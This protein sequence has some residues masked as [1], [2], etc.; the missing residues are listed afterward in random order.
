MLRLS[1][2]RLLNGHLGNRTDTIGQHKRN[3]EIPLVSIS[4]VS[5]IDPQRSNI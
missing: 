4:L 5:A 1:L 3:K 2:N